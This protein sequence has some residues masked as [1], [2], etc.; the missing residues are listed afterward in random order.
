MIGK[1]VK[2]KS[3]KQ[4]YIIGTVKSEWFGGLYVIESNGKEYTAT[5][6]DIYGTN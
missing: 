1:E 3:G 6:H 4:S 2:F 5:I